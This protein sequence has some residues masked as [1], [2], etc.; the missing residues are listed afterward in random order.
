M[1]KKYDENLDEFCQV[2]T[3]R[4]F[5]EYCK[6]H[7]AEDATLAVTFKCGETDREIYPVILY[8]DAKPIEVIL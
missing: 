6:R 8:S 7:G 4:E 2:H 1:S 3:P 5:W